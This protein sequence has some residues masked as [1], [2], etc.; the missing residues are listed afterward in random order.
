MVKHGSKPAKDGSQLDLMQVININRQPLRGSYPTQQ[1]TRPFS[2]TQ[3][4]QQ[5]PIQSQKLE[6]DRHGNHPEV[7]LLKAH[8]LT[9]S[10]APLILCAMY[11]PRD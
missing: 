11:I 1:G 10:S 6:I 3:D 7:D 4:T 9:S 2:T 5:N 8:G